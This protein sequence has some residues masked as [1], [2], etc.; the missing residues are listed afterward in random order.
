MTQALGTELNECPGFG[1]M[2]H[3]MK[4]RRYTADKNAI[5]FERRQ[6]NMSERP[7]S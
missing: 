1:G 2:N 6:K 3:A 7:K 4:H 5:E